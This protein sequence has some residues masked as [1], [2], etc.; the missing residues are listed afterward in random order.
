VQAAQTDQSIELNDWPDGIA[1]TPA[2]RTP[3][4]PAPK[5]A[6]TTSFTAMC[7]P[8]PPV[9]QACQANSASAAVRYAS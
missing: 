3:G 6:D 9:A 5:C 7:D 8:S 1:L 2:S 4:F